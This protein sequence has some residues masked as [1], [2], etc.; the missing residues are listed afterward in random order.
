MTERTIALTHCPCKQSVFVAL[1][2]EGAELRRMKAELQLMKA[3]REAERRAEAAAA[4]AP[5]EPAALSADAA[6]AGSDGFTIHDATPEPRVRQWYGGDVAWHTS[7]SGSED[8]AAGGGLVDDAAAVAP[9]A[10]PA[11]GSRR[12]PRG[13]YEAFALR[14]V[15]EAGRTGFEE[16]KDFSATVGSVIAGR[17]KVC[18][19]SLWPRSSGGGS[20]RPCIWSCTADASLL[21]LSARRCATSWARPPSARRSAAWT[22]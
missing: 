12:R 16:A 6:A 11:A 2:E 14:V 19:G 4:G 3:Q 10:S 22:S 21:A 8:A 7:P 18:T 13:R 1:E 9:G 15:Y 17:Y 5:A 20:G